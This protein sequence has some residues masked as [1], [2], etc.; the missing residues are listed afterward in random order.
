MQNKVEYAEKYNGFTIQKNA[1]AHQ[2]K[3]QIDEEFRLIHEAI[4]MGW[5]SGYKDSL[6]RSAH[7]INNN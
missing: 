4:D 2:P 5:F 6:I 1:S 3:D 7:F